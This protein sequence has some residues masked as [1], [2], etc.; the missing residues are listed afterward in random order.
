VAGYLIDRLG[1]WNVTFMLSICVM[2]CGVLL[3][4]V[5]KPDAPFIDSLK[6]ATPSPRTARDTAFPL[7]DK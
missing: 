4:F 7:A 5:M 2:A 3:T 6:P 1:N